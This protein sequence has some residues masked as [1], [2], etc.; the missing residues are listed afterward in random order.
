MTI[1]FVQ[2]RPQPADPALP[3]E[4]AAALDASVEDL[5]YDRVE[6]GAAFLQRVQDKVAAYKAGRTATP[7]V[8]GER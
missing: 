5:R 6:D 4:V 1:S 7:G 2:G 3:R 8:A